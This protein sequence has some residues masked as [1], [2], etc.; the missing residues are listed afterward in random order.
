MERNQK[1]EA[2][3]ARFL[4]AFQSGNLPARLA[5]VYFTLPD[6]RIPCRRWSIR[7]QFITVMQGH[8][9]ARGFRQWLEVGRHV[10]K[11]ESA[12]FI[13]NPVLPPSRRDRNEDSETEAPAERQANAVRVPRGFRFQ[14]VFGYDQTDGAPLPLYE[15][16]RRKVEAL[17]LLEVARAWDLEVRPQARAVER[18]AC[19]LYVPEQKRI[20]LAVENLS[21]WAHELVH[22]AEDRLGRLLTGER[23]HEQHVEQEVVAQLGG[24][25]LL[26]EL[27]YSREADLGGCYAYLK[28][29]CKDSAAVLAA[30]DRLLKRTLAAVTLILDTAD[31]LA[32]R[33]SAA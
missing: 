28:Y 25:I 33:S 13:L 12:F 17:P 18:D 5:K 15:E 23:T 9:D 27:G 24:A 32:A 4:E 30:C 8:D 3:A 20:G 7:N 29:Q 6:P 1:L 10:K 26:E 14:A 2:I 31:E 22:A 19:G 11:G 21:T 16:Q